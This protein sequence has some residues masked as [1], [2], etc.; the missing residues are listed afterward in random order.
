MSQ[1]YLYITLTEGPARVIA[2]IVKNHEDENP[3]RRI[4]EVRAPVVTVCHLDY[5]CN[6]PCQTSYLW[7]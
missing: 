4:F 1:P 6:E 3:V 2:I 7:E 5:C